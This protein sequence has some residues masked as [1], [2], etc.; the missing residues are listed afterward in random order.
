MDNIFVILN[1][2]NKYITGAITAVL[3]ATIMAAMTFG[4]AS[5]GS[6]ETK[7]GLTVKVEAA[8]A[9]T[10]TAE[11]EAIIPVFN[12]NLTMYKGESRF[13]NIKNVDRDTV[14]K[15]T[16]SNKTVA[17]VSRDLKIKAKKAGTTDLNVVITKGDKTCQANIHLSVKISKYFKSD[18]HSKKTVK[19]KKTGAMPY[20]NLSK[21]LV[22]GDKG[23]VS[24]IC[25]AE[26]GAG[27]ADNTENGA[28]NA[29]GAET[30]VPN[31]SIKYSSSNPSVVSIDEKTGSYKALKKGSATVKAEVTVDGKK[32]AFAEKIFVKKNNG[33]CKVSQ[34]EIDKFFSK[35]G[36]VGNSVSVGLK[37]FFNTKPASY[38]GG[39]KLL[40]RGSYSFR[41]DANRNAPYM[42]EY[43]GQTYQAK[44]AVKKSGTKN[45]FINM[46]TND[47]LG[48]VESVF[49]S[50]KEYVKGI[51]KTNPKA[52][53]F[54]QSMTPMYRGSDRG[55]LNNAN[56]KKLNKYL[57]AWAKKQKDVYYVN[58][59]KPMSYKDG[60]LRSECSSDKYV[61]LTI[62]AYKIW[63]DTD[64]EFVEKLLVKQQVAKDAVATAVATKEKSDIKEAKK[65][66]KK[67]DKSKLKTKLNKK[68]KK[69]K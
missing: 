32:F 36:F 40:A 39:P 14:V 64:V 65:L 7:T 20:I 57:K 12:E 25:S 1:K 31:I 45:V 47:M 42:I 59:G 67:L 38:L 54:I 22:I 10:E 68:L 55:S 3:V 56:I 18:N 2:K 26:N 41:S 43:Q 46:G 19:G 29:A 37:F 35:A 17:T 9:T 13:L 11:N 49:E 44:D 66:V 50:Y 8:E 33:R 5:D 30:A 4:G 24:A 51:Q 53:I 16:S 62:A 69:L 58:I 15:V 21:K 52:V 60:T 23:K 6:A 61:H 34:K 48:N 28:G 63:I 27:G